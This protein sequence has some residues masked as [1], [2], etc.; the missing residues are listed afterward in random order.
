M[1][2]GGVIHLQSHSLSA[3]C[4]ATGP[5]HPTALYPLLNRLD[6]WASVPSLAPGTEAPL[7]TQVKAGGTMRPWAGCH[8]RPRAGLGGWPRSGPGWNSGSNHSGLGCR[9]GAG[10]QA[11]RMDKTDHYLESKL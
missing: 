5:Q 6:S 10:G 9:D 7:A 11:L 3:A 1:G 8:R 2:R 4:A